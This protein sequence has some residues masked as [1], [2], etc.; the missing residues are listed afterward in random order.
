MLVLNSLGEQNVEA[1]EQV[2]AGAIALRH[3]LSCRICNDI[4]GDRA[5]HAFALDAELS[6]R[7]YDLGWRNKNFPIVEG[8]NGNR[9]HLKSLDD[10]QGVGV[11]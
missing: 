9:L 2:A 7:G 1:D 3:L 10:S 6:L 8:S 5:R 11:N 4:S